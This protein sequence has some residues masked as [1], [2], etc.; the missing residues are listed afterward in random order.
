MLSDVEFVLNEVGFTES[1]ARAA[2]ATP[3]GRPTPAAESPERPA[4]AGEPLAS[5]LPPAAP[6]PAPRASK[7]PHA[8]LVSV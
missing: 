5:A 6:G 1:Q 8:E 7:Q 3:F 4:A 2:I